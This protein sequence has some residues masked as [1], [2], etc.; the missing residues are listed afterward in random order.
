MERKQT[1]IGPAFSVGIIWQPK[2]HSFDAFCGLT[3]LTTRPSISGAQMKSV[4]AEIPCCNCPVT[5]KPKN[6]DSKQV[7][8]PERWKK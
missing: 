5:Q 4:L 7:S 1:L 3:F 8:G 2:P 6:S